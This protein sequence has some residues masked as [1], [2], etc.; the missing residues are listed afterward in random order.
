MLRHPPHILVTT[1]EG[2]YA[3]VTGD[4]GRR[5]LSTVRSVIVDEIHAL[6][7]DRRGAHLAL[8]LE[9]LERI[10]GPVQRIGLSATVRPADRVARFLAGSGRP[11]AVVDVTRPRVFDLSIELPGSPLLAVAQG[12]AMEEVY[13]RITELVRAH[14]ATIVFVNARTRRPATL[15]SALV[16][17]RSRRITD[18]WPRRCAC[19]PRRG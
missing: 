2:L 12:E 6:A 14:R 9:R 10:T 11:C 7:P 16:P 3:L 13:D 4:G 5:M 17:N 18:R 8:T 15:R 19:M 1:P